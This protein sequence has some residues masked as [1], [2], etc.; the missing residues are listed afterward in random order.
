MSRANFFLVL[1][2]TIMNTIQKSFSAILQKPGVNGNAPA[3]ESDFEA[4]EKE[5]ALNSP[6]VVAPLQGLVFFPSGTR[7]DAPG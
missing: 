6:R 7:G 4:F 1:K 2:I 3:R 5:T